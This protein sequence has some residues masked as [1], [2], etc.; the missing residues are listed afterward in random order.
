MTPTQNKTNLLLV[1][2]TVAA[3]PCAAFGTT[4]SPV[5][6][7]Y[8]ERSNATNN[9]GTATLLRVKNQSGGGTS[10]RKAYLRFDVSSLSFD[11]TPD[12]DAAT[13]SLDFLDS[14]AGNGGTSINWTFQVY[15][16]NDGDAGEAWEEG[17]G[18]TGVTGT[19]PPNPLVWNNAPQ[20]NT[21]SGNEML[22]GATSLGTFA[23]TGRTASVN[24]TGTNGTAV[25]DFVADS[26]S[27]DL[28][29]FVLVRDTPEP[30]NSNSYIHTIASR[31]HG[32]ASNRPMLDLTQVTA[33]SGTPNTLSFQEGVSPSVGYVADNTY[34]RSGSFANSPQDNDPQDEIIV[35]F[36]GTEMRAMFEFDLSE[37]E[38]VAGGNPFT[39]DSVQLDL[40][41]FGG[42][43]TTA[44]QLD[45]HEYDFDFVESAATWNDPD[46]DGSAGF[47]D[48]T[49]GGTLGTKLSSLDV[50]DPSAVSIGTVTLD[51][52][53]AFREAVENALASGDNTLRLLLKGDVTSSQSFVRFYDETFG[54]SASRPELIV[55]FSVEFS[56]VP[57]PSS[58]ALAA[59]GL[60]SLGSIGWRRRRRA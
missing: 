4:L 7:A 30:N 33:P 15:G 39:I 24:F 20:S 9:Y 22:S 38:T 59:L 50:A 10:E 11:H 25:R 43:G 42:E 57:E 19:T 27:D 3:A 41:S 26:T 1:A 52:R 45:L 16:L 51:N 40:T 2:V 46:G 47:G 49:P 21:S 12:L 28:V 58:F 36:S 37:I 48:T 23:F 34:L 8:G 35:G 18:Q 6:D 55:E 44:L 29:T 17:T 54:T 56:V 53:A 32:A 5:A 31:E 14:G 13:L 60:I